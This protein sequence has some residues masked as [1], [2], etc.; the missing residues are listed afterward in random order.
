MRKEMCKL[1]KLTEGKGVYPLENCPSEDMDTCHA[2]PTFIN[3]FI[4]EWDG[5]DDQMKAWI[6]LLGVTIHDTDEI[7][8]AISHFK[9]KE[10]AVSFAE[11]EIERYTRSNFRMAWLYERV[12]KIASGDLA[13]IVF[14][15]SPAQQVAEELNIPY[16]GV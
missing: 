6:K 16:L 9:T 7:V 3:G 14:G 15:K 4:K 10:D 2:S 5:L 11:K 12:K 8:W 1:C 13:P